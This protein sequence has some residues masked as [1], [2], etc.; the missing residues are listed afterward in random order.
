MNSAREIQEIWNAQEN[1]PGRAQVGHQE[2]FPHGK[3]CGILEE[4]LEC[5]SLEGSK[6]SLEVALRALGTRW[7]SQLGLDDLG[8][9]L[10]PQ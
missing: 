10:Q 8:A 7:G 1:L 6:E 5:P 4:G 9:L 2:K 3:G